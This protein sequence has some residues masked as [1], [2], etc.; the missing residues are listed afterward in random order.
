MTT[1]TRTSTRPAYDEAV[2]RE[3]AQRVLWLSAA[4]VDA[5]NAGRPNDSGVK[6][7]G[8][9]ASSA[10]MVD[11]MVALWFAELTGLDR[12]SVKP[13]ASPVLHAINYLLGDL[14]ESYLPTL[15]AKGGLQSYPSRLKDPDTVDFST[16]SVG[17]GA[18]APL[19]AAMAHR[20]VAS[21]FPSAPPAG[22]FVSLVG[23][24][25]LDEGAIWEAVADPAVAKLGE[26]LWVVD[27]NRQSLDRVVPDIQ[28][29]K[30][31]GMFA[32]AGWEV[33]ILKW[34]RR[35]SEL[36]ERDG[37]DELRSRLEA[38][39]NEEYQRIL[40]ADPAEVAD[41][42]DTGSVR[43]RRLLDDL[44][45]AELA[46]AVRDLGGHDLGLLVD[47]FRGVEGHRPT[48]VFAYTVKGRGLPTEGHPNNH[49]ALL[50]AAQLDALATAS[51][52]D[53]GAPWRRFDSS[54]PAGRL[55]ERRADDLRR[56][57]VATAS[58]LTVPGSLGH[59]H[60][61]PISTQAALG[62]LL[63]DLTRDAPEVAARVVTCSPDVASS[64]NLGGW[65]NKTGVWS[66]E[67][68]RD[69]FAD[70][71]ER[72]LRWQEV[73][74][75][76]H[77]ELGIAEV[78]L[79]SLLGELGATWSRWGERLIPVATIYDPFVARALEPWS[80]G[81]YAGGQSILVGTP[82]GV[83]LA[84]EGGAHQSIT[85]PSIGLEQPGCIA[86]EP[87]FAQDLEWCFL[88]AMERVG[89]DGGT[90]SYFRLSTRP[91]DPSLA[92]LPADEALLSQ[93]RRQAVAGGYR[94]PAEFSPEEEDVTLV[95]V[96]AIMPEV[97]AAAGAL[98][99]EGV[100]AGVVCL[101]SPDLVFRSYQEQGRL[102]DELFPAAHPAPLVTVLDGHPH[103]LSFLA[104]V[105]GDRIRCLG[106]TEF[107]QSSGL[108]DA[109]RLHGLDTGSVVDA[110]LALLA[111]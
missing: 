9:Q 54:T 24:A 37:G 38:M 100:N 51:G 58:A 13:H 83:T 105:R 34:G 39:S 19:W 98:A 102:L 11:V 95:G 103:T 5:A 1:E 59:A 43:L 65:I 53:G 22:R 87:A 76:Q 80:Y 31:Q 36:F 45:P 81:I 79:V 73:S 42:I 21:Q 33:V 77:I 7:G 56:T 55:C 74:N 104:A 68:R 107:G 10:S 89:V 49:S 35:I 110:A 69:W 8:H 47:T 85:T 82:S 57:P 20:Y 2:L 4:I 106:V 63:A 86:W 32:A 50:T 78:N 94:L 23:D 97:L 64:T 14:D 29:E 41:R 70:D 27:L 72:V 91:L 15:R 28:I 25:E 90:S 6:A 26:L 40:R 66:V 67:A 99:E 75:G 52:M 62:R 84:P 61:K 111:R 88:H 109:Y 46:D 18:T 92:Q 17:I 3:I 96:G 48:V 71:T 16:G 12:V 93:R 30:L 108:A 44:S 101:T 60:R